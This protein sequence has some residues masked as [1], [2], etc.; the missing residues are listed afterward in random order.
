MKKYRATHTELTSAA[1][2]DIWKMWLDVGNWPTWDEGVESVTALTKFAPGGTFKLRPK[3]APAEVVVELVDVRP[4]ERFVDETRLPFGTI[5]ASHF[6][7]K[8][9]DKTRLTHVIEAEIAPEQSQF[10]EQAIWSGMETGIR[11]SVQNLAKL[12]AKKSKP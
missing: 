10:F 7:E 12:A 6:I 3:G 2:K 8:D 5:R 4:N 1:P 11:Q 9:G